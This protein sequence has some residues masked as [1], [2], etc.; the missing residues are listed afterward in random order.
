M[1]KAAGREWL[2]RGALSRHQVHVL[3]SKSLV[4]LV[5][6]VFPQIQEDDLRS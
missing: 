2:V 3:L 5:S 4:T 1:V 6:E